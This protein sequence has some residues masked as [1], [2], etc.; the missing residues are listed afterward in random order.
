MRSLVDVLPTD[1]VMPDDARVEAVAAG[2]REREQR[3]GHVGD[4][5]E[6]ATSATA[7]ST[8]A[9]GG[10]ARERVGDEVVAVALGAHRDEHLAGRER[11]RVERDAG[12]GRGGRVGADR[13]SDDPAA[14]HLG[15]PGAGQL[16]ADSSSSAATTRS[17]NGTRV[18]ADL[19][20][21]LGALAEHHHQVAGT[22]G[23]DRGPDRGPAVELHGVVGP[24][25]VEPACGHR[26]DRAGIL[27]PGVVAR[28]DHDVG[29]P[30]RGRAHLG[31]LGRVAVA[32][33]PEHRDHAP[34]DHRPRR[35]RARWRCRRA[36]ARSR[37]P[38]STGAA[39]AMRS[40][41]P[42]IGATAAMPRAIVGRVDAEVRRGRGRRE[43]V[44]GVEP[45][46]DRDHE[47]GAVVARA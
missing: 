34:G 29:A 9:N 32:T 7:R 8:I 44:G 12:P 22:G 45:A 11:A 40:N 37:R 30:A 41:R 13:G 39:L 1:P 42:G 35:R 25:V 16:H 19:L 17:S 24:G 4:D 27:R 6:R 20:A 43:R 47:V 10:T 46:G 23:G 31:P 2:A 15:H 38:P 28:E 14:G 36:C 3:G 18:V 26:R 21:G 33:A 5:D